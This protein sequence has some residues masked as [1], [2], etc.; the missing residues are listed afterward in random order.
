MRTKADQINAMTVATKQ[1][2]YCS[3]LQTSVDYRKLPTTFV[4]RVSYGKSR[5]EA[6]RNLGIALFDNG[7]LDQAIAA[8]RQ[9]IVLNPNYPEACLNL[10]NALTVQ[11]KLDEAIKSLHH[12]YSVGIKSLKNYP[13]RMHYGTVVSDSERFKINPSQLLGARGF[14]KNY[15]LSDLEE[16]CTLCRKHGYAIGVR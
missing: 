16:I 13:D 6:L 2:Y 1:E 15:T 4:G 11:G 7:Q 10:G 8:Y 14:A 9:A 3:T 5:P 12:F